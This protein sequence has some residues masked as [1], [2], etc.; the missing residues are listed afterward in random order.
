MADEQR[1]SWCRFGGRKTLIALIAFYLLI[2]WI[3]VGQPRLQ[4]HL[5]QSKLEQLS[6]QL[7]TGVTQDE[8]MSLLTS[9]GMN[10]TLP[11]ASWCGHWSIPVHE[12][13]WMG[14][15]VCPLDTATYM[16]R[17]VYHENMESPEAPGGPTESIECI[18]IYR[19]GSKDPDS[20]D[21]AS[22]RFGDCTDHFGWPL[23]LLYSVPP[24]EPAQVSS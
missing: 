17:Y 13:K 8:L 16:V 9:C 22:V 12:R 3:K 18:E 11:E 5:D 6:K 15:I 1:K 21:K 24:P 7:K 4:S 2:W 19:A 20:R 23:K 14:L 10:P